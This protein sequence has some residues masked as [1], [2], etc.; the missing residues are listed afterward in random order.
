MARGAQRQRRRPVRTRQRAARSPRVPGGCRMSSAGSSGRYRRSS[1][2][3]DRRSRRP[4]AGQQPAYGVPPQQAP[5]HDGTATTAATTPARST[6][7]RRA[8][9]RGRAARARP[10]VPA[11]PGV[12]AG[13]RGRRPDRPRT[14]AS[15]SSRLDRA[16]H[17]AARDHGRHVLLG[18]LQAAPR[19]RPLQGHRPAG[20]G[21]RHELP[22]RRLRQPRGPVR[23]GE[24]EAAHR[25]RRGQAH[26]LDDDPA[27]RHQRQH[28][29]LA[30][31]R[32]GRGDPVLRRLRVRARSSRAR[33]STPS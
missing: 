33:A 3:S 2:P 16:R 18:R 30:A 17:G 31:A 28:D 23:R 5:G 10:P 15:A 6:G 19:G 4:G 8:P 12:P 29:D 32:L 22:D 1:N 21:R 24:E 13:G 14:G 26:R 7:G 20:G 11:A 9:R 27:H 25:L